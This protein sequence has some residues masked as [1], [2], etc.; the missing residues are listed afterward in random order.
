MVILRTASLVFAKLC[1][2]AWVGAGLLFVIVAVRDVTSPSLSSLTKSQLV[3]LRFPAYYVFGMAIWLLSMVSLL[4]AFGHQT[5]QKWQWGLTLLL[6]G[7]AG[8]VLLIDYY[9]IY[10]PL[11]EITRQFDQPRTPRFDYYHKASMWVN[12]LQLALTLMAAILI[13]TPIWYPPD[14]A[15]PGNSAAE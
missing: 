8:A 12:T 5:L 1:M 4:I 2:S 10:I 9:Y 6:L 7:I 13:S 15:L 14:K 11:A 3:L